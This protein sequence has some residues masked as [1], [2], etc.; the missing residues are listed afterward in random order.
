MAIKK[1][2]KYRNILTN[3]GIF[4]I[5]VL[6]FLVA[7]ELFLRIF[8]PQP[9]TFVDFDNK[10]WI[11][12]YV[13]NYRITDSKNS[14]LS[15]I[16]TYINISV[17]SDGISDRDYSIN[18][19]DKPR[20]VFAG[21]SFTMGGGINRPFPDYLEKS[22][23]NDSA[24]C[25]NIGYA[26][27]DIRDYYRRLIYKGL[28]YKPDAV[29]IG[30]W[31]GNDFEEKI[32]LNE[33]KRTPGWA[34]TSLRMRCYN[35]LQICPFF[36]L[37]IEKL[38]SAF[39]EKSCVSKEEHAEILDS[40]YNASFTFK[41]LS[42]EHN[43]TLVFVIIPTKEQVNNQELLAYDAHGCT[44]RQLNE[45]LGDFFS[46]NGFYYIDLKEKLRQAK[47]NNSFY[48]ENDIHMNQLG[49]IAAAR[50][51]YDYVNIKKLFNST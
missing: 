33:P 27:A 40:F 12:S 38:F 28:K 36:Y 47:K 25:I 8:Y 48:F 16:L 35:K 4:F 51:I 14:E 7:F 39:K 6:L 21:D 13:S 45:E 17:N 5:S 15:G 26:G 18:R 3:I 43:F 1:V 42:D 11:P 2:K 30:L 50:I 20:Y 22:I 37:R 9:L 24:E 49:H 29:F 46:N 41:K 34:L 19:T 31:T 23:L 44:D 32:S 10:F